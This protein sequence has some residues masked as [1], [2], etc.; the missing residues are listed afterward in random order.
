V[1]G[2]VATVDRHGDRV[3]QEGHVVIDDLDHRVVTDKTV[4][5]QSGV[6]YANL[7]CVGRARHVK[8]APMC[9]GNGEQSGVAAGL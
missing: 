6:E 8:Q 4:L 5:G 7:G 1:G 2:A 3:D 9:I